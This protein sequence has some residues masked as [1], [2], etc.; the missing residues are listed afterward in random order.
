MT[1]ID[2]RPAVSSPY[3]LPHCLVDWSDENQTDLSY[4]IVEKSEPPLA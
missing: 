1:L 4:H 2:L 3:S